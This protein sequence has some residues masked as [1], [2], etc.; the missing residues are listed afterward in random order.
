MPE[1]P[2]NRDGD[3]N[4]EKPSHAPET[5][6]EAEAGKVFRQ[7]SSVFIYSGKI[8]EIGFNKLLNAFFSEEL[9]SLERGVL[10]LT[11]YG[12][13]PDTAYKIARLFQSIFDHFVLC[14]PRV[15][16]SA[17]TLIALGANEILMGAGAELGPLDAQLQQRNEIG[18][19]RSGLVVQTAL[20][21]LAKETLKI[22][23]RLML[24]IT[25]KSENAVSFEVASQIASQIAV[26]VM[27]P[28][29]A[30]INPYDI[31]SDVRDLNVAKVYGERLIER[32]N[33][34]RSTDTVEHLVE[35]YPSHDFVIDIHE[36]KRLFT[37][38]EY[39]A[40]ALG[41]IWD[42]M[43]DKYSLEA[44]DEQDPVYVKKISPI[45]GTSEQE[46]GEHHGASQPVT[47][48]IHEERPS[49]EGTP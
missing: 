9:S 44:F 42:L 41:D 6:T 22:Y 37:N 18:Q 39:A 25:G 13:K 16:K 35:N 31:G 38:V 36:A 8:Y 32:G 26:G 20:E 12:G 27:N 45:K 10:I 23:E 49:E 33:N 17:G 28:V 30:Q 7:D 15:C 2:Q 5:N 21:E 3:Q 1:Q 34:A 11:S 29:Y 47:E 19:R 43:M 48:D 46:R 14:V 4:Q 40:S 24:N